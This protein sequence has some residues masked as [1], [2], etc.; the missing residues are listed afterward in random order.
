MARVPGG[1]NLV[2]T[3]HPGSRQLQRSAP[4]WWSLGR[5]ALQQPGDVCH[6]PL[7][8]AIHSARHAHC[9]WVLPARHQNRRRGGDG[10]PEDCDPAASR[11]G[12]AQHP[13]I[14]VLELVLHVRWVIVAAAD[15]LARPV[16][17]PAALLPSHQ[18][19]RQ[20]QVLCRHSRTVQHRPARCPAAA[21]GD[22]HLRLLPP[23][24]HCRVV[25]AHTRRPLLHLCLL[26]WRGSFFPSVFVW[27]HR[28]TW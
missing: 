4:V 1:R 22:L 17:E 25:H 11:D 2:P 15:L 5:G 6:R 24:H 28:R 7:Q 9:G 19:P 13:D 21:D 10:Q 12:H 16:R 14:L 27:D 26:T 23:R 20:R 3:D 8:R 18:P